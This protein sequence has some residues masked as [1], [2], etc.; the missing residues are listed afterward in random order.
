MDPAFEE[1]VRLI[2]RNQVVGYSAAFEDR[3]MA[4]LDDPSG[5]IN[6][7]IHNVFIAA[8]GPEVQ[9]YSALVRSLDSSMG[10]LI[11]KIALEIAAEHFIV[12]RS[13]EGVLYSGQT[14]LVAEL[15]ETYKARR[16]PPQVDDY[17]ALRQYREGEAYS[18]RHDS[19]Y[20]LRNKITGEWALV[21]LKAGG[22]LDNKKARSEKEALLEQFSILCN[23]EGA[24]AK[25][26]IFFAT[27][28]NRYGEGNKW[29]QERVRQFFAADELL[30][31][32]EFWNFVTQSDRGY[33]VVLDEYRRSAH[34]LRDVLLRVKTAYVS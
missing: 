24:D 29:K 16:Q 20:V 19:D 30:I 28:Y 27:A 32:G 2:V 22:D 21:E 25:V 11:E 13:V 31:S 9:F 26:R 15:L 23:R 18:K 1:R 4:D 33:D 34:H 6:A 7:K 8:L 5:T 17:Q 10:S 3:H 14:S 12:E